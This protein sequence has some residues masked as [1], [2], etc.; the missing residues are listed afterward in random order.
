MSSLMFYCRL[1]GCWWTIILKTR[2][3]HPIR[4]FFPL[5]CQTKS[6]SGVSTKY[7]TDLP[8]RICLSWHCWYV[9]M[10]LCKYIQIY[11]LLCPSINHSLRILS[12]DTHTH[13]RLLLGVLAHDLSRH[14]FHFASI[15]NFGLTDCRSF[16]R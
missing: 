12:C 11:H 6:P 2:L 13:L 15:L 4:S 8:S 14:L 10:F 16:R 3:Y 1:K 9:C 5:A 7:S